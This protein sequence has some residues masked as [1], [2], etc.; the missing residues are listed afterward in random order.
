MDQAPLFSIVITTYHRPLQVAECLRSLESLEYPRTRFETI[1]VDDGSPE[2]LDR[3]VRPFRDVLPLTLLRQ[4]NAGPASGRNYGTQH[5]RGQYL[6]FTDDDC[7]PAP[8][9][10]TQLEASLGVEPGAMVGGRTV[11][12]L[13]SRCSVASQTVLDMV[14]QSLN[15]DPEH[16]R[17]FTTNNLALPRRQFLEM[18]GLAPS[19]TFAAEDRDLCD[20]WRHRGFPLRYEPA[21]LVRHRHELTFGRFCSQYFAYGRGAARFHLAR[22]QRGSSRLL[23]HSRLHLRPDRWLVAPVLRAEGCVDRVA[24]LGL[25][26]TWQAANAAGYVYERWIP[27]G[28]A[29]HPSR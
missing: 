25:L 26:L 14:H 6:A 28:R 8:D 7:Q 13:S 21:A 16:A 5:A 20:R 3:I 29:R 2:P 22:R 15:P 12:A 9:W 24:L 17:F 19:F 27:K 11:N 10:L 18:G 4:A 23:E 1:V